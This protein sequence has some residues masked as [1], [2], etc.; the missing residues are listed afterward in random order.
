MKAAGL[1][2]AAVMSESGLR[3]GHLGMTCRLMRGVTG[4]ML[5][6]VGMNGGRRRLV[7][8]AGASRLRRAEKTSGGDKH[9]N[10]KKPEHR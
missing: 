7:R 3:A 10:A 5:G 6:F 2:V 1:A 8:R 9:D 4:A